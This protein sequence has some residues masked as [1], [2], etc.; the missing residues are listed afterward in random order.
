[1][2]ASTTAFRP[3]GLIKSPIEQALYHRAHIANVYTGIADPK[4]YETVALMTA[5]LYSNI[6][7]TRE[8]FVVSPEQPPTPTSDRRCDIVIRYLESGSENIRAL[9]FAECKRASTSRPFSLKALEDQASEY[10]KLYLNYEGMPFV[11]AAT[12][13]GA[14]VRLWG[15]WPDRAEMEPFWGSYAAGDWRQYKDVGDDVAAREI[16]AG[17]ARMKRFPPTPHAGQTSE[18]YGTLYQPG[19]SQYTTTLGYQSVASGYQ[20]GSFVAS[21]PVSSATSVGPSAGQHM[22]SL[23]AGQTIHDDDEDDEDEENEETVED[24][25]MAGDAA[26]QQT[27]SSSAGSKYHVVRLTKKT[28]RLGSDE[29]VFTDSK[30]KTRCTKQ[31][32]WQ[33]ITFQGQSAWKYHHYISYDSFK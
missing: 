32:D 21:Y 20:P 23:P 19:I 5:V 33:K 10:C 17:F 27:A 14:H 30:G 9:C 29:F 24:Y 3:H 13:A 25:Q 7:T 11:Y 18:T 4:E 16:E 6:F 26:P 8:N 22:Y 31:K 2:M 28:H 15:C 1:M 12:M